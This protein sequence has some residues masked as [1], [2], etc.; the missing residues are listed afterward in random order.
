M[1]N[2]NHNQN[3][4][5]MKLKIPVLGQNSLKIRPIVLDISFI[6][7]FAPYLLPNGNMGGIITTKAGKEWITTMSVDEYCLETGICDIGQM[8]DTE[9]I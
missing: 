7:E 2:N 9:Q 6:G 4:R 1:K 3:S 5:I 8:C